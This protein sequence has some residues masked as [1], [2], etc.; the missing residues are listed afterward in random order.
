MQGSTPKEIF[1]FDEAMSNVGGSQELLGELAIALKQELPKLL[2]A[3]RKGLDDGDAVA[4]SRA[5]HSLKGSITPF[6]AKRSYDV[7]WAIEQSSSAGDISDGNAN[8]QRLES[9]LE[10]LVAALD[11]SLASG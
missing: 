5:A 3:T 11:Q 7:A 10:Q 4:V 8:F 6:A 1:D 2:A 9:E